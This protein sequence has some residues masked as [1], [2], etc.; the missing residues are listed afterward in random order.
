VNEIKEELFK[1]PDVQYVGVG[2]KYKD[3]QR[4]SEECIS[5]GVTEKKKKGDVEPGLLIPRKIGGKK[6]DVVS[7][8]V[9]KALTN[10]GRLRPCPPG[11][12]IGHYLISAGTLGCLV[13]KDETDDWWILSNN[14]V[15]ANSNDAQ[16][17][18]EIRQPGRVDGGQPG[19]ADRIAM[20]REW[21]V[22]NF[23]GGN[24][25][26]KAASLLWKAW[27][28][29]AN[30]VAKAVNCPFRLELTVPGAVEQPNPNLVDA[31]IARPVLQNYVKPEIPDI[32]K[33][34]GVRN[35]EL[36]ETVVKQG[37]TTEFTQ[38]HVDVI[39]MAVKVQY[40]AGKI[41]TFDDQYG[42]KTDGDFSQGGDSGSA[43]LG[44]DNFLGSLLFAGS[45]GQDPIT[46]GNRMLNVFQLL[47]L[48]L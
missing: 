22:I 33:P 7:T 36:G 32:G 20:L 44:A 24:G 14:H 46:I 42:I 27:R 28:W 48:R 39:D 19:G 35:F 25:K 40:G 26:K 15:L 37:R 3:G 12:S 1:N 34:E 38:G 13:K 16:I 31:A 4:T 6:T 21:V 18:D 23:D 30:A 2:L 29:P 11:Y 9:I 45:S 10:V 17:N 8:G 47:G 43:I 5:V 41:A